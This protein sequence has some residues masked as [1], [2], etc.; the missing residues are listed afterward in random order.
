VLGL[1]L[2]LFIVIILCAVLVI[3]GIIGI[4]IWRV[5]ASAAHSYSEHF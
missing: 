2:W 5:K 4:I 3:A 1:P